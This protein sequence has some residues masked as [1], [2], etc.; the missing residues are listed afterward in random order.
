M[1]IWIEPDKRE[2]FIKKVVRAS[3]HLETP[4]KMTWGEPEYKTAKLVINTND[5]DSWGQ[6]VYKSKVYVQ[7]CEMDN[8]TSGDWVMVADIFFNEQ[9]VAMVNSRYYKDMPE[10]YGLNYNKCDHCGKVHNG[11]TRAHVIYNTKTGEWKQIGT[12]CGKQVFKG[13]DIASFIVKLYEVVTD[14]GCMDEDFDGWCGRKQ[15]D[16]SF[17]SAY[18]VDLVVSAVQ[19]YRAEVEKDWVKRDGYRGTYG[20]IVTEEGTGARFWRFFGEHIDEIKANDNSEYCA[21]V[22]ACVAALEE[23][24]YDAQDPYNGTVYHEGGFKSGIKR[25]YE[26][27][28]ILERDLYKVYFGVK[29]YEDSLTA[30]DWDNLMKGIVVGEKIT[31]RNATLLCARQT[32]DEWTNEELTYCEFSCNGI[33]YTK[34]L[35]NFPAFKE[36]Y[37]N[38][39]ETFSF[40]CKVAYIN[41]NKRSVKLGGRASKA[42]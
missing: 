40:T 37:Q 21:K 9:V 14:Y 35:S 39:D 12:S 13:G 36:S 16:H 7:K 17:L 34:L 33:K 6:Q 29:M 30:G 38:E 10:K 23:D 15:K 11:R 24:S 2:D 4:I 25:A 1:I 19:R 26:D 42:K 3:R 27:G 5:G 41:N 18:N 22:R 28:F 20:F 32:I 31:L 8:I